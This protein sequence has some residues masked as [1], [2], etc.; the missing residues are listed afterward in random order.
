M[1]M[2]KIFVISGVSGVGKSSLIRAL[3]AHKDFTKNIELSISYTTRPIRVGE[4]NDK[5][6]VFISVPEFQQ[7]IKN[8][9][10]IEYATV[11]QNYYGTSQKFIK[12]KLDQDLNVIV[13]IDWQGALQIKELFQQQA[14]LMYIKP[15][16]WEELVERL[17]KRKTDSKE[18]IE[19]RLNAATEEFQHI[20]H[21]HHVVINDDFDHSVSQLKA[22]INT[23]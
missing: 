23:Q 18:T 13:E 5:D 14:V 6:Y 8:K 16:S 11:Y 22:I 20:K 15:P 2:A 9:E 19:M 12:E 1:T 3:L 7:M 21:Y 4:T 10:F 17:T